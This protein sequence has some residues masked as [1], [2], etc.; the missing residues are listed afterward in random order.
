[1][2][3]V[4]I[5]PASTF[6]VV[7]LASTWMSASPEDVNQAS[8][9][10]P[11]RLDPPATA[12]PLFSQQ[13]DMTDLDNVRRRGIRNTVLDVVYEELLQPGAQATR[14]ALIAP[15][16]PKPDLF[17]PVQHAPQ[18][19]TPVSASSEPQPEF[20]LPGQPLREPGQPRR[21]N[22]SD[23][24]TPANFV[25]GEFAPSSGIE[26]AVNETAFFESSAPGPLATESTATQSVATQAVATQSVATEPAATEDNT[27]EN[28]VVHSQPIY[29]STAHLLATRR[30]LGGQ[31]NYSQQAPVITAK[32]SAPANL[33]TRGNH[34]VQIVVTND[35]N[36]TANDVE[37]N[38][39]FPRHVFLIDAIPE[40]NASTEFVQ[41]NIDR[42]LPGE[43]RV[44]KVKLK[45]LANLPITATA[46][47]HFRS[48]SSAR[49][50]NQS[51]GSSESTDNE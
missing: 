26:P 11:R 46:E 41:W 22:E 44:L 35:G 47:I 20:R 13:P 4:I 1:M 10:A 2:K 24:L 36:S 23:L 7:G 18:Q 38:A 19:V 37:L 25:D 34:E 17:A 16:M 29:S 43:Q 14:S 48:H 45:R 50:A 30:V 51:S 6:L 28:A 8:A 32:W 33:T 40:P 42:L 12:Q 9:Q 5:L 27:N 3:K 15:V 39:Y 49:F 31:L 21:E